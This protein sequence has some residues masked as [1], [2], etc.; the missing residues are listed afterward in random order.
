MTS[1]GIRREAIVLDDDDRESFVEL[2]GRVTQRFESLCRAYCLMTNHYHL[3]VET[4]R[5]NLAAGMQ[6]LNS[7]FARRFNRRHGFRGH[8]FE[9]RYHAVLVERESQALEVS[10]YVALNPVRAGL[11]ADPGAWPWSS[12]AAA[13]GR[14][15]SPGFLAAGPI[16][17]WFG[18]DLEVARR[19]YGEFV[20]DA[21]PAQ[22]SAGGGSRRSR[23][24]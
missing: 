1:R 16:L 12:F 17:S 6:L 5:A 21:A 3:L 13:C 20:A 24:P 8:L 2:L 11:C 18:A 10:R 7:A 4:P 9:D 22:A 19:R 23:S 15:P 14:E